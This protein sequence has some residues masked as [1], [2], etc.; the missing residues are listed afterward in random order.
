MP[1]PGIHQF[2]VDLPD[3]ADGPAAIDAWAARQPLRPTT[4]SG[5]PIRFVAP[6][7]DGEDYEARIWRCGAVATRSGCA[8]D[9]CNALVWLNFPQ[10]KAAL[11]AAHVALRGAPGGDA[12]GRGAARDALTHFD[13]CGAIVVA[14]DPALLDLI[15]G[16]RWKT[17]FWERRA[18]VRRD[19]ALVIF[20]HATLAALHRPFRGLTAKAVLETVPAEWFGRTPEERLVELDRRVARRFAAVPRLVPRDLQ[21][22]PLLGWPGVVA[23]SE[24]AAYYDDGFQFRAGRRHVTQA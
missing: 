24:D 8:H 12:V 15:R 23:A 16:F 22:L 9:R 4:G 20:G 3:A 13:E 11:N 18:D 17:L 1:F 7:D 10:T 14:R 21:P 2:V 19:M 6:I 5:W